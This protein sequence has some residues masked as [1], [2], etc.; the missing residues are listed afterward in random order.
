M[1]VLVTGGMGFVGREVVRQLSAQGDQPVLL[2]R[3]PAAAAEAFPGLAIS[4]G[5]I[6]DP[7]SLAAAV[8][9]VEAVIH[10]VGIISET[11]RATFENIHTRGT[12][13][14]VAS[15]THG[16]VRRFIHMS[17]LGTRVN[18]ASR[19]HQ[20][21]WLAEQAVRASG[22]AFTI[23]R[24]SLIFGP[25]DHF[26]N[27]FARM[28]RWSPAVPVMGRPD[29]RF[30]PVHVE[31][32]AAA[33]VRSLRTPSAVG[34]TFDLCGEDTLT[35]PEILGVIG[36]VT[37]RRR[38]FLRVP[39]PLAWFQATLLEGLFSIVRKP[40]PLNRDQLVMLQEDNVGNMAPAREIF[41]LQPVSFRK[42]VA[43]YLTPT[44]DGRADRN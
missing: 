9:G 3:D 25:R 33:F 32:V 20:S 12:R 5:D 41:G 34:C 16:G 18:A 26:V 36:Q 31:T 30:Q 39:P 11:G 21:K 6:L 43:A 15:A 27:L 35:F 10:L 7:D 13:N 19:Y 1:K 29:A 2:A 8:R 37:G 44:D 17:A 40:P 22:L 28:M 24:P 4:G 42:G 38:W 14:V 23:F